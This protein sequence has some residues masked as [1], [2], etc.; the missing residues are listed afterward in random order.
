[1]KKLVVSIAVFVSSLTYSQVSVINKN[2][3]NHT[4]KVFKSL[5]D[6]TFDNN[7]FDLTVDYLYTLTSEKNTIAQSVVIITDNLDNMVSD[8][9]TTPNKSIFNYLRNS[10]IDSLDIDISSRVN[11]YKAVGGANVTNN[12]DI[13]CFTMFNDN[14]RTMYFVITINNKKI[15]WIDV[16]V[17]PI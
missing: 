11:K 12:L 6:S 1:M 8:F 16:V 17:Y 7:Q 9:Y 14:R 4:V 13:I 5:V 15:T 2:V 3:V 10:K